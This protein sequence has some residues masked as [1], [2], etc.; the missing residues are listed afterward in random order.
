[1][2]G[3]VVDFDERKGYG[4]IRDDDGR[5]LFFHCTQI[6]DGTRTIA[7]GAAVTFDVVA[8]HLGRWEATQVTP[9][10]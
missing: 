1:M 5:E 4:A 9:D 3:S 2:T 8:G 10:P 6:A 7:V